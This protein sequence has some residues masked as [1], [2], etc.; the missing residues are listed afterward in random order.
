M[1]ANRSLQ[2]EQMDAAALDPKVYARV[3][4]D[5]AK[6]N[7]IT[8]AHRATLGFLDTVFARHPGKTIRILDVGFGEGDLLRTIA[9]H[10]EKRGMKVALTGIDLNPKS[11]A[12][13]ESATPAALP[14]RYLAGDYADLAGEGWDV[15]LSSLVAHHMSHEQLIMFLRFMEHEG[16]M[17]WHIN[18]LHR[19][20]FAYLGYPLLA[21]IMG[22]HRIV[23]EDGQL[24]IARSY[25]PA[26]WPPILAQAGITEAKA[27]RV[28]P[29]RLCVD[30]IRGMQ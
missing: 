10:A 13:A 18:D 30:R 4:G 20:G 16:Q 1:L 19:H 17:G 23:R 11:I 15:I 26:E 7:R 12:A 29:F 27:V 25:R 9:R 8:M 2:E 22:W 6:V 14:I 5:L 21:R 24:S 3:L 28:F